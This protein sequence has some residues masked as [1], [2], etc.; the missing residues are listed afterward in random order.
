MLQTVRPDT[1]AKAAMRPNEV[2]ISRFMLR[3]DAESHCAA[4]IKLNI[5][6]RVIQS[7]PAIGT[8]VYAVAVDVH[9]VEDTAAA[10]LKGLA[11]GI[12]AEAV[13]DRFTSV[14]RAE[15]VR[16]FCVYRVSMDGEGQAEALIMVTHAMNIFGADIE[17]APNTLTFYDLCQTA[18]ALQ[19]GH[20]V[21]RSDSQ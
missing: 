16:L 5:S 11:V 7:N 3:G 13:I 18:A 14:I 8:S 9:S 15:L 6:A 4:L 19:K 20:N 2:L 1:T 17:L 12:D 10:F 21:R